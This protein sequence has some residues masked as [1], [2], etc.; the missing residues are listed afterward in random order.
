MTID[1]L[2]NI[3]KKFD[4]R[5]KGT[6]FWDENISDDNLQMLEFLM[7]ALM[8]EVGELANIEKIVRGDYKLKEKRCSCG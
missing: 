1:E 5:Y 6:F 7:I 3:Q 8:G 4:A 2:T